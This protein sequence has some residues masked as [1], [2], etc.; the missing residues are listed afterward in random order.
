LGATIAADEN[1][2]ISISTSFV[3]ISSVP[4]VNKTT[5]QWI[6]Y[7]NDGV[8]DTMYRITVAYFPV[9]SAVSIERL[10]DINLNYILIFMLDISIKNYFLN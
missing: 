10:I 2:G 8:D 4:W 1:N 5:E 9:N 7:V 6:L 3:N